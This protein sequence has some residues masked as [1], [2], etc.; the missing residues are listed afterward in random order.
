MDY[1]CTN[2]YN[3]ESTN[4]FFHN[5]MNIQM[6]NMESSVQFCADSKRQKKG[7]HFRESLD[8]QDPQIWMTGE[9]IAGQVEFDR[10]HCTSILKLSGRCRHRSR[11]N[12][13][14]HRWQI[15]YGV[16]D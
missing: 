14:C 16:Y 12:G 10:Y 13:L 3:V 1:I 7:P 6:R 11:P 2:Q 15:Q 5:S 8:D 4:S 9:E